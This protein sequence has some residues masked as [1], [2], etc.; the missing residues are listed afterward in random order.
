MSIKNSDVWCLGESNATEENGSVNGNGSAE[1]GLVNWAR[2]V[3]S[4]GPVQV[5]MANTHFFWNTSPTF[6]CPEING[7]FFQE[8][9]PAPP[10][11]A[12]V[13]VQWERSAI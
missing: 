12:T 10:H 13:P 1:R 9:L 7:V 4:R 5:A 6:E 11:R 3:Y 8:G 2:C